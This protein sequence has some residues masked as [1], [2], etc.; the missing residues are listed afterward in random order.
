[1]IPCQFHQ[2]CCKTFLSFDIVVSDPL[3]ITS[4]HPLQKRMDF[5]AIQQGFADLCHK[6][7]HNSN[8]LL[9]CLEE[10][11]S[12]SYLHSKKGDFKFKS[13]EM[14]QKKYA[15]HRYYNFNF[16]ACPILLVIESF[17]PIL[18]IFSN[19]PL[20]LLIL[21]VLTRR[22]HQYHK[23]KSDAVNV[24]I[25]TD[26]NKRAEM[27]KYACGALEFICYAAIYNVCLYVL[28]KTPIWI[29]RLKNF[30]RQRNQLNHL[31]NIVA[32]L[33]RFLLATLNTINS[34]RNAIEL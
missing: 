16:T 23:N 17:Y 3:L 33:M 7:N 26:T 14:P 9:T 31:H 32:T 34:A 29:F 22:K 25:P 10:F 27:N 1:M 30:T 20:S 15:R 11:A 6:W 18:S 21:S 13:A 12:F 2:T 19:I 8:F 4:N 28:A 5:A 24:L